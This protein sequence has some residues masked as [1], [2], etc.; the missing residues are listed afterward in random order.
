MWFNGQ[1]RLHSHPC[2]V[3]WGWFS[4]Q[5]RGR[6]G[7]FSLHAPEGEW[8]PEVRALFF[9]RDWWLQ[10][11]DDHG[12]QRSWGVLRWA[13]RGKMGPYMSWKE[14]RMEAQ[15][16]SGWQNWKDIPWIKALI[17]GVELLRSE[18]RNMLSLSRYHQII[19]Q[20]DCSLWALPATQESSDLAKTEKLLF[21]HFSHPSMPGCMWELMSHWGFILHFPDD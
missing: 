14:E 15:A 2:S 19:F 20:S 7:V 11:R 13:E 17:L 5:L 21:F 4:L 8:C 16:L 9:F 1:G 10:M 3:W 6:C 12:I 18:G